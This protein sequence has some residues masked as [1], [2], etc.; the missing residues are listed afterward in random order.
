[1]R[2]KKVLNMA[3][4]TLGIYFT[5]QNS[6]SLLLNFGSYST[7]G[8]VKSSIEIYTVIM[9]IIVL[10]I[11]LTLITKPTIITKS[12]KYNEDETNKSVDL[13]AL[14]QIILKIVSILLIIYNVQVSI[15]QAASIN[16]YLL[17]GNH[18]N[19]ITWMKM[20]ILVRLTLAIVGIIIYWKSYNLSKFIF[21]DR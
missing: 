5:Y 8:T 7:A 3:I 16:E 13:F 19:Q 12:V 15:F 6:L 21:K 1:M 10:I 9:N 11:G 18:E 17:L 20:N 2:T 4:I 14:E